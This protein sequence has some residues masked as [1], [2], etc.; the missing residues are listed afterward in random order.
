M[1]LVWQGAEVAKEVKFGKSRRW[2][3][4]CGCRTISEYAMRVHLDNYHE[5][6]VCDARQDNENY[7][8]SVI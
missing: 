7:D 2:R 8:G 3:C 6:T 1:Y 4:W 5:M